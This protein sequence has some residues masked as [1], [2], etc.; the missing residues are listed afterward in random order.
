M[1]GTRLCGPIAPL[2][3]HAFVTPVAALVA[4]LASDSSSAVWTW[5][6]EV[7]RRSCVPMALAMKCF[8]LRWVGIGSD[9]YVAS[10]SNEFG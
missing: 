9:D 3:K 6:P 7:A 10:R 8:S 5:S 1:K 2:R 4:M